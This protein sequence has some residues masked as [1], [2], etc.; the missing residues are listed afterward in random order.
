MAEKN[1]VTRCWESAAPTPDI[2]AEIFLVER[3]IEPFIDPVQRMSAFFLSQ[4]SIFSG[5]L[6]FSRPAVAT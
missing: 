6:F 5:I 1:S 4:R 3:P 2:S